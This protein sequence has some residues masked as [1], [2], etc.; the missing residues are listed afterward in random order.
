[1]HP[2]KHFTGIVD[3]DFDLNVR[4]KLRGHG[5]PLKINFTYL[6]T[7]GVDELRKHVEVY[8]SLTAKEPRREQ[9]LFAHMNPK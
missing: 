1:M 2:G 4:I 5:S 3:S 6:E 9:C 8:L 7:E